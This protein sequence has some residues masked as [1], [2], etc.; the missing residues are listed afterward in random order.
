MIRANRCRECTWEKE[1]AAL[2]N[3]Q[4][5]ESDGQLSR[6]IGLDLIRGFNSPPL[7]LDEALCFFISLS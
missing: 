4:V 5:R 7:M 6:L 1:V 2:N 3:G